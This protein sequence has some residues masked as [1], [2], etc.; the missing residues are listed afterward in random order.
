MRVRRTNKGLRVQ[1]I[2]GTYVV[3]LGFDLPENLCSGFLGFSIH[4]TDHT[5]NEAYY[6]KGMKMFE[7][8]NPGFPQGSLYSTQ[9]HPWQ[10]YQWAD[11]SAKPDHSYTYTITALKGS[12]ESLIPIAIT[13]IKI[14]TE[15]VENEVHN[16]F[17][18]RGISASQEYVRRFGDTKPKLSDAPDS[19]VLSWLSRGLYEA[20]EKFVSDC[21][22][23]KDKLRICAYEFHYKP[24]LQLIK[25]T[26]DK[27]V[28][29]KILYD[30]RKTSPGDKNKETIAEC[31]LDAFCIQRKSGKSYISHNKFIVKITN[32]KPVSVWT[33]GTNFSMGGIFGH[34]NVAHVFNDSLVAQK[35]FDY[36]NVLQT[37]PTSAVIKTA[38]EQISPLP[39]LSLNDT[40]TCIF[41]PRKNSDALNLYQLFALSAKKGLFMTFAFGMNEVFK[42]VY[43]TSLADLRFS[44]L[45]KKTRPLKEGSD[46]RNA[47]EEEIDQLRFKPENIFAIGDF[48]KTNQIDGW[49]RESLSNLNKNVQYVHNK[50]MLVDPLS[51][52]PIVITGSANFSEAST[53]ENDENM[54]IVRKNTRVADIYLGEYMRL[55][56]HHAFRES[57]QW[58]S[59]NDAPKFLKTDDWWKD[60]Y[61]DHSRSFRRLYFSKSE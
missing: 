31:G 6:M 10:S 42:K 39:D 13:K 55:Y 59:T 29:I 46:E 34:S 33:G 40:E 17:F 48:I 8:T 5:E 44:L 25:K 9:Y 45:E 11:Y 60:Y 24:F 28:D 3:L 36:W 38:T 20:L 27:G 47:E 4:R 49:V 58:R 41:S 16:I 51:K 32:E 61:S 12:P 53:T 22:P 19:P 54:V 21:I 15:K 57:L 56:S 30:C 43:N 37:D 14:K 7:K 35:F 1:A 52:N 2:S 18:N 50:F 26:I 23:G